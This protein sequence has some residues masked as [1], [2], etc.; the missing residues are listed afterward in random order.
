MKPAEYNPGWS[1]HL[2]SESIDFFEFAIEVGD[3][4]IQDVE[5]HLDERLTSRLGP[6]RTEVR[7]RRSWLM[8]TS[9]RSAEGDCWNPPP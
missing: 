5:E 6:T 4:A 3:A 9:R 7:G 8:R 1:Y 2:V